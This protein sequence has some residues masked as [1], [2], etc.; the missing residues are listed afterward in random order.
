MQ[1]HVQRSLLNKLL[2]TLPLTICHDFLSSQNL[3]V[4]I[5][6]PSH[7]LQW[8]WQE[9]HTVTFHYP[10]NV[11]SKN[12]GLFL[13]RSE[14]ISISDDRRPT[15]TWFAVEKCCTRS[16]VGILNQWLPWGWWSALMIDHS[17]ILTF[18][19][20]I[21]LLLRSAQSLVVIGRWALWLAW[22]TTSGRNIVG[23][24]PDS[25]NACHSHPNMPSVLPRRVVVW[26]VRYWGITARH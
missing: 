15:M 1:N 9:L 23:P 11:P 22:K 13:F 7:H 24:I 10:S 14:L 21:N 16:A 3:F 4:I 18:S 20:S 12:P 5:P 25:G 26:S 19:A 2:L 6:I 8:L 17:I